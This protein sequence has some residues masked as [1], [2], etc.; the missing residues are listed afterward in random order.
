MQKLVT[1]EK[2]VDDG[3]SDYQIMRTEES[4]LGLI[5]LTELTM[6]LWKRKVSSDDV[7]TW[8]LQKTIELTMHLWPRQSVQVFWTRIHGYEEDHYVIFLG[9]SSGSFMIQLDSMQFNNRFQ[10]NSIFTYFPYT[11]F[12]AADWAAGGRDD[13]TEMSSSTSPNCPIR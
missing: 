6:Q 11:S 9:T 13:G 1:I 12:Y 7:A 4:S 8:V 2:P 5:I 10:F 3:C